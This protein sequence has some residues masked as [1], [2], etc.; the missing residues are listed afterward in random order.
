MT[1]PT[2]TPPRQLTE[3][4][5]VAHHEAGHA[6]ALVLTGGSFRYVTIAALYADGQVAESRY[7]RRPVWHQ[8]IATHAAGAAA[9]SLI[10][11]DRRDITAAA[12]DDL[13]NMRYEARFAWQHARE[14]PDDPWVT[15]VPQDASVYDL[16]A[17][18]WATACDLIITNY[19]SLRAIADALTG[20]RRALTRT[21]V[22]SIVETAAPALPPDIPD[23]M[24]TFWPADLNLRLEWT[25]SRKRLR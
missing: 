24:R 3:R 23:D 25:P 21:Q 14:H 1:T 2:L 6:L 8:V 18:G 5:K 16:A 13:R 11:N 19:G 17:T 9:E 12:G 7:S 15:G 20:S 10:N 22:A 4:D